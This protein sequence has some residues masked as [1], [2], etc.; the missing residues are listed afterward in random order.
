MNFISNLATKK[1][2]W[3]LLATSALGLEFAALYFQYVMELAPCIMCI[4][5]RVAIWAI[6]FAG[7]VGYLA[8]NQLVARLAGY[9]LWGTGAIWGLIIALE[10]VEMQSATLSL[11]FTCDFTPNFPSWAPLHEW[12]PALFE[13][14]GDCGEISW[15]FLGYSMPQW[16]VVV[17]G[18]YT[19]LLA[20]VL[21][22]RIAVAKNL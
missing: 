5:Q 4:Y 16:M 3:G 19:A 17:Y 11:F 14:T 20:A 7:V 13:A 18:V 21:T 6:F 12:L 1:Q 9:G 22:T 8:P 15:Q 2:A 10:H